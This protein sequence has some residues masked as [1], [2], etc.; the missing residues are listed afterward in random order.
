MFIS[1]THIIEVFFTKL[2]YNLKAEAAKTYLSY[3]W[4]LLEPALLVAVFYVVFAVFLARETPNFIVFLVCGK[5]PFLWYSKSVLNASNSIINGR[6]LINQVSIPKP[7]F[8][9]LVVFQD[10]FKQAVVFVFMLLFIGI[11]SM[12]AGLVWVSVLAVIASQFLL[13][14]ASALVVAAITPW[15]PDFRYLISTAMM[16]LMFG[17]GVFYSYK[18][19]I[20]PDHQALFL[21]NPIANLIKNYRQVLM[22]NQLPDWSALI[23]IS[24]VSLLLIVLM[25]AFYKKTDTLYARLIIQ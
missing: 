12:Q 22:E 2:A 8:P 11:Y 17:S 10:S 13:I 3:I 9:L 16:A 23:S 15:L 18:D 7:F 19:V 1:R 14:S 21:M 20:Q 24:V 6:G 4:W 25:L 5:I